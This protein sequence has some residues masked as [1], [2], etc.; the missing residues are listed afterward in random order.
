MGILTRAIT[1]DASAVVSVI[2][3]TDIANKIREI[4][5]TT[6]AMTA[7]LGSFS[8][9]TSIMGYLL[10]NQNDSVTVRI[11][12]SGPAGAM[13][14]TA[15]YTGNVRCY[16]VNAEAD[17]PLKEDKTQDIE[18]VIGNNVKM[19]VMKYLGPSNSNAQSTTE[20][21]NGELSGLFEEYFTQSDQNPAKCH[22]D[23]VLNEDGSVKAAGAYLIQ[24]LPFVE[25]QVK[26][27][28]LNNS[29]IIKSVSE[30]L[31][32]G[33]IPD[34]IALAL[35][36]GKAASPD[37]EKKKDKKIKLPAVKI[38]EA[39]EEDELDPNILDSSN[40]IY[41]CTCSQERVKNAL[42]SI[43]KADL[44]QMADEDE[45]TKVQCHFCNHIYTFTPDEIRGLIEG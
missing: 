25:D 3:S 4:H 28:I 10:K 24:F 44:Q 30:E 41:E 17:V 19:T 12:G 8:T 39:A 29:N 33:R 36:S 42:R 13:I 15:E 18:K 21:P 20:Y 37:T 40:V 23:I 27:K 7:A 14:A 5:N 34:E 45:V 1:K 26:E 11:E 9:M 2:D 6:P 32:N 38:E 22:V 35:L 43:G 31:I 16:A